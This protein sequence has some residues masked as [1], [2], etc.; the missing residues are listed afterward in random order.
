MAK[1]NSLPIKLAAPAQRA[2]A[3][4]GIK[5][6]ADFSKFSEQE[7]A[8]LHGIGKNALISIREALRANGIAF[9]EK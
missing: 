1:I 7:I 3:A 8:N 5:S 4:A 9:A 6:L 2:L